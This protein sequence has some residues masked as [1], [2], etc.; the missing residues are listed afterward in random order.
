MARIKISELYPA[1][2]KLFQDSETF[3]SELGEREMD[4]VTGGENTVVSILPP[5]SFFQN[6]SPFQNLSVPTPSLIPPD[7]PTIP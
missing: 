5:L 1:G 7:N 6:L 4:L 2:S 3:L